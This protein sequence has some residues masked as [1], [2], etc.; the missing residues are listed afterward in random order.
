VKPTNL[1]LAIIIAVSI[2]FWFSVGFLILWGYRKYKSFCERKIG[3]LISEC[4]A[5]ALGSDKDA[6]LV[7]V[8]FH[9]YCGFLV[10]V[11]QTEHRFR[12]PE[13]QA[14]ELV[15]KLHQFN[16]M[17]GFFAY[18]GLIIPL[19]SWMN[20]RMQLSQIKKQLKVIEPGNQAI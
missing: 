17:W 10:F 7:A 9:T 15:K 5:K 14:E 4:Q 6:P 3:R 19:I 8:A 2:L 18:G 16:L 12:L 11:I 13:K 20:Y 1:Q